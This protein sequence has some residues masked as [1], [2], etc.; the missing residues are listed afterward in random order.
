MAQSELTGDCKRLAETTSPRFGGVTKC[1]NSMKQFEA[2]N[3]VT[4]EA[5][6]KTLENIAN[7]KFNFEA[8]MMK[9]ENVIGPAQ[10]RMKLVPVC[11]KSYAK[12]L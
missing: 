10:E 6:A 7:L 3:S 9:L 11:R 2:V 4:T 12:T 8:P 5:I 1:S